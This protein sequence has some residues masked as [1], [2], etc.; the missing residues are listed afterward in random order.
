M[1]NET[2]PPAAPEQASIPAAPVNLINDKGDMAE[3]WHTRAPEGYE[4]LRDDKTLS[5]IKNI[6]DFGKSH[7]HM[8]KQV[9]VDKMPRP[10]EKWGDDD[11]NEFYKAAGRPET[12]GDYNIQRAEGITEEEMP[13]EVIDGYQ[14]LFHRIGLSDKQVKAIETHNNELSVKRKTAQLQAEED[15]NT[16]LWDKLHDEW[17]RAYDQKVFRGTKAIERGTEGDEGLYQ[18]VL[19]KVNK[20]ADLIKYVANM[21]DKFSEHEPIERSTIPT[22]KDLQAQI[23]EIM[24]DPRYT[25][26]DKSVRQPL[27]DRVMRLREQMIKDKAG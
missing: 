27:I 26:R 2:M 8:R 4:D 3:N 13:Q 5:T 18:R 9:P 21:E 14:D 7:V 10:N 25:N 17:G 11:W 24:A 16:S 1:S 20:D 6:W 15:F 22:P 12:P 23:N 19:D